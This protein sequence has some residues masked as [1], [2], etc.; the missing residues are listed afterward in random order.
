[1]ASLQ[2][3]VG[4]DGHHGPLCRLFDHSRQ[5]QHPLRHRRRLP[6]TTQTL[7]SFRRIRGSRVAVHRR[8]PP[9]TPRYSRGQRD[10]R[11]R[12]IG[13]QQP[14]R[15]A[16]DHAYQHSGHHRRDQLRRVA[17][18][19]HPSRRKHIGHRQSHGIHAPRPR[20]PLRPSQILRHMRG[21]LILHPRLHAN[22]TTDKTEPTATDS[23]C[24][25]R[26]GGGSRME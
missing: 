7:H 10:H 16:P 3:A 23:H 24:G 12:H 2:P 11:S 6:H 19:L 4:N 25:R 15:T 18:L 22:P 17:A 9:D 1:M 5:L 8:R 20:T 13:L 21:V 26:T 14:D